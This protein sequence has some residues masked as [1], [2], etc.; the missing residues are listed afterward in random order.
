ME[1][2]V[3]P[4]CIGYVNSCYAYGFKQLILNKCSENLP[5]PVNSLAT[6]GKQVHGRIN[7]AKGISTWKLLE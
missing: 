4:Q 7:H 2:Y 5:F 3:E 1:G 6:P